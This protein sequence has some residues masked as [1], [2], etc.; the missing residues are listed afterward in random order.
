MTISYRFIPACFS[1]EAAVF[2]FKSPLCLGIV[3]FPD[4][5]RVFILAVRARRVNT[6][7]SVG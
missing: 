3:T 7:P 5:F 6:F 1:I 4:F 2:I